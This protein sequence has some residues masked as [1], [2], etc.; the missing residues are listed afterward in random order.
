MWRSSADALISWKTAWPVLTFIGLPPAPL[1]AT[2]NPPE[3]AVRSPS[4]YEKVS[5]RMMDALAPARLLARTIAA[6]IAFFIRNYGA[7]LVEY[8]GH[9]LGVKSTKWVSLI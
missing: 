3:T 1:W 9:L 5:L 4:G 6:R 2:H 8:F 7:V